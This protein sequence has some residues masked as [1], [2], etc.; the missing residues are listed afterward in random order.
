MARS[1][2]DA[3]T[4]RDEMF[5]RVGRRNK[6][7]RKHNHVARGRAKEKRRQG[8]LSGAAIHRARKKKK[9]DKYHAGV[10]AYWQGDL[11]NF[12]SSP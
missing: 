2:F 6:V 10:R 12:P 11:E 3:G 8:L 5:S 7:G 9:L 4:E 1:E